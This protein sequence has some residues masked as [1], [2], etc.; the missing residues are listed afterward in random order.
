[1]DNGEDE[2]LEHPFAALNINIIRIVN[3]IVTAFRGMHVSPA[4]HS[5]GKCDRRTDRQADD[6]Q[7]DPYVSLCF[8][9]D[10]IK[11]GT[12]VGSSDAKIKEECTESESLIREWSNT[13]SVKAHKLLRELRLQKPSQNV[14]PDDLQ[15]YLKLT[16]S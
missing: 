9:G 7:S 6:G 10:I 1:M 4:K 12:A 3:K 2:E 8:A 15:K 16:S 13:I 11:Y 14:K 5:F